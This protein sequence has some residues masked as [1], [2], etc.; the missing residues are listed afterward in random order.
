MAN[1]DSAVRTST[2]LKGIML[3]HYRKGIQ[4]DS[5]ECLEYILDNLFSDSNNNCDFKV[6]LSTSVSWRFPSYQYVTT[7]N[8]PALTIP[9]HIFNSSRTCIT[10]LLNNYLATHHISDYKCEQCKQKGFCYKNYDIVAEKFIIFQLASFNYDY[11]SG[12]ERK[13]LFSFDVEET[14]SLHN[15]NFKL[16]GLICHHGNNA[17]S[18]HYT[19]NVKQNDNWFHV[20]DN[21]ITAGVKLNF[22]SNDKA[23]PYILIYEGENT[24]SNN[25]DFQIADSRLI[26]N[27]SDTLERL[28]RDS[29]KSELIKQTRRLTKLCEEKENSDI[30]TPLRVLKKRKLFSTSSSSPCVKK[31]RDSMDEN[32]NSK[33]KELERTFMQPSQK[34]GWK[35]KI[36]SKGIRP[37]T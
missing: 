14:L 19:A 30:A 34:S 35:F 32:A 24:T 37:A 9:F 2:Y 4:Y 1:T 17:T 29:V 25:L 21:I 12:Q 23:L 5:N 15:R 26:S 28:L 20:N 13:T 33:V 3:P 10:D 18:G 36:K 6:L 27:S 11:V 22:N 16:I 8:D 7:T 31:Y